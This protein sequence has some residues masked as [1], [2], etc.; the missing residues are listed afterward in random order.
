M[1]KKT[2]MKQL[3]CLIQKLNK[4]PYLQN[5]QHH[6]TKTNSDLEIKLG[7]LTMKLF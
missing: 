3:N 4:E 1:I 2:W 7:L 5:L 6:K